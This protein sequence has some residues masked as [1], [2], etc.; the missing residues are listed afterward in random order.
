[1]IKDDD[2]PIMPRG[3]RCHYDRVRKIDVILGPERVLMLDAIGHAIVT[4]IDGDRAISEITRDLA[5][6]YDAP[7]DVIQPD[8][9]EYLQDLVDK[10]FIHVSSR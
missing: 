1:M 6:T 7:L 10:G 9:V 3:V 8:V 2:V 4:R 5:A